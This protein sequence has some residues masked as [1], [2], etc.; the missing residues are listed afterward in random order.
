LTKEILYTG[1]TRAS[2]WSFSAVAA[3]LEIA[4]SRKILRESGLRFPVSVRR[5]PCHNGE[6]SQIRERYT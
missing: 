6:R 4:I 1:I 2:I 5:I 3:S